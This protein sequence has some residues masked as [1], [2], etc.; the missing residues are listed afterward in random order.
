MTPDQVEKY[1]M[2]AAWTLTAIVWTLI[3]AKCAM[4]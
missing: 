3:L 4:G 2:L 1:A